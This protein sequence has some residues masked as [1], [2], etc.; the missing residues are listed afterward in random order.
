[1]PGV[2]PGAGA[3]ERVEADEG[4]LRS[5]GRFAS[6]AAMFLGGGSGQVRRDVE[7]IAAIRRPLPI[8]RLVGVLSPVAEGGTSTVAA[9]LADTLAAQRSDRVLAV[10]ADPAEA[11]LSRRLELATGPAAAGGVELLRADPTAD[12]LRRALGGGQGTGARDFGLV[13]VD[14]PGGM[15]SEVSGYVGTTGHAFVVTMP[16]VEHVA[17]RCLSELDRMPPEGQQLLLQ[18]AVLAI[19]VVQ[20]G[21]ADRIRGLQEELHGRGL[22]FVVLPYDAHLAE[23]WPVRPDRLRPATRRAALELGARVVELCTR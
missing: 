12:G 2:G 15:A 10:D 9:L 20:P 21:D 1:M 17:A 18:R 5:I 4:V 6:Q 13:V 3:G 22:A 7:N 8:S 23:T 16:S 11:E 19:C 14:C